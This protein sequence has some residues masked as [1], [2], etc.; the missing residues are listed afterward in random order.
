MNQKYFPTEEELDL[1]RRAYDGTSLSLNRI[2]RLMGGKYPRWHVR[3]LAGKLGLARPKMQDWSAAEESYVADHYP[4]MGIKA[5]KRALKINFGV[6]RS[7]TAIGLKIKRL[8]LV[9]ADGEGF[10]KNG[11]CRLL[12]GGQYSIKIINR[13]MEKGWLKGK[14]RGTLRKA[15]QGGDQYYFSPEWVR[16]F[17]VAHPEEID[18]RLVDPVPFI[19]LVAGDKEVLQLC[20]C[21]S[22]GKEHETK[23]LNP[24]L[25]MPRIYCPACRLKVSDL[26]EAWALS[27]EEPQPMRLGPSGPL[28]PIFL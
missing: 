11:L 26:D 28:P 14:R 3:K 20:K 18:L 10:T 27:V 7:S 19:R 12:F 1:I 9:S 25:V 2:M 13:W 23:T 21:P 17:I 22:C 15:S 5:L 4:Q 24:G 8:G 16:S 6:Q